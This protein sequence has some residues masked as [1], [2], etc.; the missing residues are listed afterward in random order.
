MRS[1]IEIGLIQES[2]RHREMEVKWVEIGI[3]MSFQY[4]SLI[5]KI[6]GLFSSLK[7]IPYSQSVVRT[8]NFPTLSV[9]T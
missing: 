9:T 2:E 5:N 7:P 4:F 3:I 1:T 6:T 8:T